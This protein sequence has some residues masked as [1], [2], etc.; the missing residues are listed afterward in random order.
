MIIL[1]DTKY[2]DLIKNSP[3]IQQILKMKGNGSLK[4]QQ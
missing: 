3:E 2:K 1:K 4:A